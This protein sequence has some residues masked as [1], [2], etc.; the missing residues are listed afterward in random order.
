M[1]FVSLSYVRPYLFALLFVQIVQWLCKPTKIAQDVDKEDLFPRT[2]ADNIGQLV[3]P[4]LNLYKLQPE[5]Q[6][7]L[8]AQMCVSLRRFPIYIYIYIHALLM[9][10][11]GVSMYSCFP[12]VVQ[13][14]FRTKFQNMHRLAM[15]VQFNKR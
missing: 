9:L 13:G 12:C 3:E 7:S 1:A 14:T 15:A 11:I 10:C 6:A 4:W 5:V 2:M 8:R